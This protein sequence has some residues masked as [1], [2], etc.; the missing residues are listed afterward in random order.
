MKKHND[1]SLWKT[2]MN[3]STL[4]RILLHMYLHSKHEIYF[5]RQFF[6][7]R[8]I[9]KKFVNKESVTTSSKD[10]LYIINLLRK[11]AKSYINYFE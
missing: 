10:F 11:Y 7:V 6:N 4:L 2:I 9:F 8:I 3:W 5:S 1:D